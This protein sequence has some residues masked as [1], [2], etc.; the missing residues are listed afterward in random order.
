VVVVHL[1]IHVSSVC[2]GCIVAKCCKIGPSLLRGWSKGGVSYPRPTMFGGNPTPFRNIKYTKMHHFE[3]K[4]KK[5]LP[6][7]APQKCLGGPARMF[8]RA[9]LWISTGLDR[10]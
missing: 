6:R 1:S 3:K 8:P 7:G 4:F 5:F 10:A 2:D 9:L